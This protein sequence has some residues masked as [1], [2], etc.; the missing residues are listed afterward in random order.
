MIMFTVNSSGLLT[1]ILEFPEGFR[2]KVFYFIKLEPVVITDSNYGSVIM[3]GMVS[4]NLIEDIKALTE[5]V[6]VERQIL[7][8]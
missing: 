8:S 5:N 6:S 4:T 7:L 1:P 2:T 3:S